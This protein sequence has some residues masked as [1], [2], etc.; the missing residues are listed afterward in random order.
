[1]AAGT[2][3]SHSRMAGLMAPQHKEAPRD[4]LCLCRSRKPLG[5]NTAPFHRLAAGNPRALLSCP[6]QGREGDSVPGS[7]AG[8]AGGDVRLV[9][10]KDV[11]WVFARQP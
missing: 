2:P 5:G 8:L 10:A 7:P 9:Q 4:S 6:R 1:M 3:L 11:Q